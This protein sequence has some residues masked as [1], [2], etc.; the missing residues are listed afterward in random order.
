MFPHQGSQQCLGIFRECAL[1]DEDLAEGLGLVQHPGVHGSDQGVPADKVHLK[2]QDAEQQVAVGVHERCIR[3]RLR[4]LCEPNVQGGADS[5]GTC[6]P[7]AFRKKLLQAGSGRRPAIVPRGRHLSHDRARQPREQQGCYP[8]RLHQHKRR[9]NGGDVCVLL[10]S[11]AVHRMAA[12]VQ[13]R[14][15]I[16]LGGLV[17]LGW[18]RQGSELAQRMHGVALSGTRMQR[19]APP[20]T[21]RPAPKMSSFVQGRPPKHL[22]VFGGLWRSSACRR[23]NL[24]ALKKVCGAEPEGPAMR[25]WGHLLTCA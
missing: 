12:V 15:P 18:E 7:D 14:Q 2:S 21:Y 23:C 6:F 24:R 19:A 11:Y 4:R 5:Y 9:R 25:A 20:G 1:R 8:N 22:A 10:C 13:G 3:I 16:Y 17:G